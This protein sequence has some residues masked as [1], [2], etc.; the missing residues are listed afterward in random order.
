MSDVL[1]YLNIKIPQQPYDD[2]DFLKKANDL[3]DSYSGS[4]EGQ[5]DDRLLVELSILELEY[6]GQDDWERSIYVAQMQQL[7]KWVLDKH[8]AYVLLVFDQLSNAGLP[9][10]PAFQKILSRVCSQVLNGNTPTGDIKREVAHKRIIQQEALIE[11]ALLMVFLGDGL[12]TASH[13]VSFRLKGRHNGLR[14]V[15]AENLERMFKPVYRSYA[16]G[17]FE[18]MTDDQR[19]DIVKDLSRLSDCLD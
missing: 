12:E 14:G 7:Y 1:D 19:A 13:K 17:L 6:F 2:S 4:S 18:A 5:Q 10:L 16:E 11:M 3:A 15:S 8:T 9:I